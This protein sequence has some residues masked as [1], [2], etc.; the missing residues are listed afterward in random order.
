MV[1]FLDQQPYLRNVFV[2]SSHLDGMVDAMDSKRQVYFV[3]VISMWWMSKS[4]HNPDAYVAIYPKILYEH[5]NERNLNDLYSVRIDFTL[6]KRFEL[7]P[8]VIQA[9]L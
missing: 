1:S 7:E 2:Q 8:V 5:R 9:F 3:D 6:I 4:W